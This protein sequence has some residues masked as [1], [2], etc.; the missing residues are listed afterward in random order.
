M[1]G[2]KNRIV[3]YSA[4]A[5]LASAI[6]SAPL[7]AAAQEQPKFV[8]EPVAEKMIEALPDGELF[9]HAETFATIEE[10]EAAATET[11]VPAEAG[12]KVWLLT[13]GP[14][15]LGQHGGE[16]VA[17]FGPIDRFDAP[18]Y[19][20]RIN[21]T[22][23]P[24]GAKTSVHSHP[25]SEAIYILSGEATIRWPDSTDVAGEGESL[26]GSPPHTAMEATSTGDDKLV[27]LVM[28]VV[29]ATQPFSSPA[30][31]E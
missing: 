6:V 22:D 5:L 10:A 16:H 27:E 2:H 29:D 12:G 18:E 17:S 3:L 15:D 9:W 13:L 23:A 14:E 26:T 4:P 24:P 8:V 1:I 7:G 30:E 20:L 19:L 21:V 11:G 25:G 31:L 28:F